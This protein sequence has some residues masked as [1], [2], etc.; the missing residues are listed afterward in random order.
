MIEIIPAVMPKTLSSLEKAVS[1]VIPEASVIQVDVMDGE[2]VPNVSWPYGDG[3]EQFRLFAEEERGLPS[4]ENISYEV[5][6]MTEDPLPDAL[7][8]ISAGASRIVI[9]VESVD[10][11]LSLLQTIRDQHGSFI[12]NNFSPE[13]GIAFSNDTPFE[14]FWE[15]I[16]SADF[17]QLMGIERVGF[18]GEAFDE[19]VISRI[20]QLRAVLPNCVISIDGAVS[21]ETAV[22]LIE[23]GANRLVVGSAIFENDDPKQALRELIQEA[24]KFS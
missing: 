14:N 11:V 13:L 1:L 22:H 18:Q 8:W 24:E 20:R 16:E 3:E 19:R 15:V 6:L 7:R 12:E 23:A 5:D 4:W 10:N 21:K 17:I 9:H 2:F